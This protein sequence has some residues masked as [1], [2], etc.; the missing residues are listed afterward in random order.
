[1]ALL[2]SGKVD[3]IISTST[4]GRLPSRDS[5]KIRRKAIERSIPCI[6]S[7]DHRKR[8][9]GQP[10]EPLFAKTTELVDINHMRTE[11]MR[12]RFVKMN[13]TSNDYIYFDCFDQPVDSPESLSVSLS[14][15]HQGIGGDGVIL[16]EA[17]EDCG[18]EDAH[19]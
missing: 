12:L 14:G 7:I 9:G 4:K 11:K 3:Y 16:I 5:V 10:Q 2:E 18:C 19:F 17:V 6:T 1:M 8:A 15:R 13:G